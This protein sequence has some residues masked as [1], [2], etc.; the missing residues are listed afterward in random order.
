MK[1]VILSSLVLLAALVFADS[2][3]AQTELSPEVIEKASLY[4][5]GWGLF[6]GA[7]LAIGLAGLGAGIGMGSAIKGGLEGMSRNPGVTGTLFKN[8]LVGVALIESIAIYGLVVAL[9]LL[10]VK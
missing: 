5:A 2:S 9:I 8:L 6:I 3:F 10:F 4:S 7:G 1:K